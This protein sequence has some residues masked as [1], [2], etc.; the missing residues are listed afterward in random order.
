MVHGLL[1]Y[2]SYPFINRFNENRMK[3]EEETNALHRMDDIRIGTEN[4]PNAF[5]PV[6]MIRDQLKS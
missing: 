6:Y 1:T 2:G 5:H 4:Q 3:A